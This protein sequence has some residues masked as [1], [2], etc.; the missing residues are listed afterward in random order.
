MRRRGTRGAR[1]RVGS[2]RAESNRDLAGSQVDDGRGNEKWGNPPGAAF[3]QG[4]MLTL[5]RAEPSDAGCNEDA[6][7]RRVF[8]THLQLRVGHREV[9]CGN[10]ELNEDVHL[11]DV[12]LVDE[13]QRVEAFHLARDPRGELRRIEPGNRSNPAPAGA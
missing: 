7:P 1:R 6:G 9:R 13:P 11:L 3:D 2:F 4:S 12:F 5:D 10:G 8:R